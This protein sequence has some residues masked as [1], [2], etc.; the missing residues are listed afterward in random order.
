[1]RVVGYF[2]DEPSAGPQHAGGVVDE[3]IVDVEAVVAAKQRYV[4]LP[5]EH[6]ALQALRPVSGT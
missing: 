2:H 3:P 1:M 5:V 6:L 4:R